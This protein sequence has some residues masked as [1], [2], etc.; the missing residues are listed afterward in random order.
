MDILAQGGDAKITVGSDPATAYQVSSSTNTFSG[1]LPGLSFTV[2]KLESAVALNASVDGTAVANQVSKLVDAV[3]A[4][5]S[6]IASAT[7][8]DA[9]SKSGGALVG[10]STARSLQQRLLALVSGSVAPGVSVTRDGTVA[11]DSTA[12]NTAFKAD[13]AKV[14]VA[15]G[16]TT[17]FVPAPGVNGTVAFSSSRSQTQAGD[18]AVSVSQLAT[19]E[20]WTLPAGGFTAGK[21]VTIGR[22][23]STASYTI[24][25]GDDA[26]AVALALNTAAANAGLG[27][28]AVG[29]GGGGITLT[30][31]AAGSAQAF[32]TTL[33]GVAGTRVVAGKDVAGTID[34]QSA[35]GIGAVLSLTTGTGGA[36]YLALDTSG[37]TPA[38]LA[39]SGGDVGS[40]SYEPG[41]AQQLASLVDTETKSGTGLITTAKQG[42][43]DQVKR[44]QDQI[45][46]WDQRLTDYRDQLTRQFTAM[47]T[48][49]ATLKSQTSALSG[50]STSMLSGSNSSS[51]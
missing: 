50:L 31:A 3:N 14:K 28:S 9:G 26:D 40:V 41:L 24:Q 22:G 47:E 5:L 34:G 45:D 42:R 39:A 32:T 1:I 19:R 36:Q 46:A 23:S 20:Q 6:Q 51:S 49:L 17:S 15:F 38:D 35:S 12:F 13:P 11:F 8:Y 33:G 30:A 10:D 44:L 25:A 2:S 43:L 18:Y 21:V 29:N 4:V 27:V 16:A 37:L 7:A 48:A